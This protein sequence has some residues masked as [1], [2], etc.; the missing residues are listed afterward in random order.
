MKKVYFLIALC[1]S[2]TTFPA[3]KK[4]STRAK[5]DRE[6]LA[7]MNNWHQQSYTEKERQEKATIALTKAHYQEIQ[8]LKEQHAKEIALYETKIAGLTTTIERQNANIEN[9]KKLTLPPSL[10]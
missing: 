1:T 10:Y 6:T 8:Q 9:Q 5:Q 2:L 7:V 4:E 3:Q